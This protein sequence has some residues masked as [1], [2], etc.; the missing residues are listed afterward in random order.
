MAIVTATLTIDFTSNYA[1][2]HRVCWR[3]QGSGNP[4][5]CST[6][7][8][9]VGGNTACQAIVTASVN[10]T[11]CD[12]MITFEG[13][14]QAACED[15][16]STNGRL[17]WTV[18]FTPTVVCERHE[19]TCLRGPIDIIQII[20]GGTGYL[21]GDTVV[22]TRDGGDTET[23]DATITI[24]TVGGGGEITAFTITDG[25]LYGVQPTASITSG[26]GSGVDLNVVLLD[27]PQELAIG[28]DCDSNALN[29]PKGIPVGKTFAMCADGGIVLTSNDYDLVTIGC[30]VAEDSE[31]PVCVEYTIEHI[32][33]GNPIDV[34]YTA[35][36]GDTSVVAVASMTTVTICA[37]L[38]GVLDEENANLV[39]TQ[40]N[41]PCT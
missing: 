14:V 35:C 7:V 28:V 41:T 13:Y 37:I 34:Q 20:D 6:L 26:T 33:G 38:D 21:V 18:D 12:G 15:I 11:S 8:N 31:D 25:G 1:G 40:T 39:I 4:Y 27:C 2:A 23:T 22:I 10:D 24:D 3:L 9:C 5:N 19:I 16:L 29:L 32:A 17:T 36:G 30:C